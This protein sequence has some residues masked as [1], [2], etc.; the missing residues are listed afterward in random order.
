VLRTT[1]GVNIITFNYDKGQEQEN[2]PLINWC[3]EMRCWL[4]D[5]I[6]DVVARLVQYFLF[7]STNNILKEQ[8]MLCVLWNKKCC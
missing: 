4:L 7:H 1:K 2:L 3:E 6:C 5:L 8:E